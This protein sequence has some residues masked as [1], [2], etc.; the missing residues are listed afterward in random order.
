MPVM[1]AEE[2]SLIPLSDME[3]SGIDFKNAE[4]SY[5]QFCDMIEQAVKHA[6]EGSSMPKFE[7]ASDP[8]DLFWH[9]CNSF[10]CQLYV[11]HIYLRNE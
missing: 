9:V 1:A 3:Y 11:R 2:L 10:A 7:T 4:F 5:D 8:R 6:F